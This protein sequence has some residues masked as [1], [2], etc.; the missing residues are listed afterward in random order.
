MYTIRTAQRAFLLPLLG[1]CL[2]PFIVSADLVI[3]TSGSA[4]AGLTG[5]ATQAY[6]L[7]DASLT[8]SDP[9]TAY[10]GAG[11]NN[12]Q[13]SGTSVIYTSKS[14]S[15]YSFDGLL[16]GTE[17]SKIGSGADINSARLNLFQNG[18]SLL[19]GTLTIRGLSTGASDWNEGTAT[20]NNKDSSGTGWD[21]AGGTIDTALSGSYGTYNF[22][23]GNSGWV[24]IDLTAA[25]QAYADGTI[26]GIVLTTDS[27][28]PFTRPL[29]S[30]D[31][32]ENPSGNSAVLRVDQIPEPAV[33]SFMLIG[34][35][36]FY[37][38]RRMKR[39]EA[40]DQVVTL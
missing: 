23:D 32:K 17:G 5:D 26:G 13:L 33:A 36:A 37:V 6:T 29:F 40:E 9:N 4:D 3:Y 38:V 12:V 14:Y 39:S 25:L 19:S 18:N 31:S 30:V 34:S 1:I 24:P 16:S 7:R 35:A 27:T 8:E 10:G 11:N 20:W 21:G 2:T 28:G 22:S 15:L